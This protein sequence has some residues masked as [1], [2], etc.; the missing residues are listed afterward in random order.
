LPSLEVRQ[1]DSSKDAFMAFHIQNHHAVFFGIDSPSN[2][3]CMAGWSLGATKKYILND[4][5]EI[6]GGSF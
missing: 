3:L 6:N 4:A 5:Y 2:R 1:T